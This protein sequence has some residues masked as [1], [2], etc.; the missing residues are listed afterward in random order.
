MEYE[1]YLDAH[2]NIVLLTYWD[3]RRFILEMEGCMGTFTTR[4]G[5]YP[6]DYIDENFFYIGEF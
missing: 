6:I 1:V 2:G 3:T 5:V 4:E